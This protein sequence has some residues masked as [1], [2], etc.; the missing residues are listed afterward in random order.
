[1]VFSSNRERDDRLCV[2]SLGPNGIR[3]LGATLYF[4]PVQDPEGCDVFAKL[5]MSAARG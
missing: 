5:Q 1:M 3:S 2:N 4:G